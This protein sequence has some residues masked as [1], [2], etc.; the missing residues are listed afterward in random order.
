M[1]YPIA[2]LIENHHFNNLSRGGGG[3]GGGTQCQSSVATLSV[4][5]FLGL[6][7]V[8]REQC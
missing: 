2:V 1:L 3:G 7:Q 4:A 6:L 8:Y 5:W